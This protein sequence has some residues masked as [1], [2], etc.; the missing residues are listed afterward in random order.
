MGVRAGRG[1]PLSI[2]IHGTLVVTGLIYLSL[3]ESASGRKELLVLL[4]LRTDVRVERSSPSAVPSGSAEP[5]VL[6]VPA[7]AARQPV[8]AQ[9]SATQ[10][11]EAA[12]KPAFL[13]CHGASAKGGA[14]SAAA[15]SLAATGAKLAP[16]RSAARAPS[17][18]T[19]LSSSRA[20]SWR[21]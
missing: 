9:P 10:G 4:V 3:R 11:A 5:G 17:P 15:A 6:R 20:S 14:A 19:P 21:M 8:D 7:Q 2:V 18:S 12:L 1:A 16:S 13:G